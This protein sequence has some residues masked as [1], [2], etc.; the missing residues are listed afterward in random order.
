MKKKKK[1]IVEKN[2]SP[3]IAQVQF[4]K[5]TIDLQR[6]IL[7]RARLPGHSLT[8][9]P[10]HSIALQSFLNYST[11]PWKVCYQ[12]CSHRI[13]TDGKFSAWWINDKDE[14][15]ICHERWV[16]KKS[17][18]PTELELVT[19]QI[20]VP[21]RSWVQILSTTQILTLSHAGDIFVLFHF[22]L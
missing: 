17:E 12:I 1:K 4:Y 9:P 19:S 8:F 18:S 20:P 10:A 3:T 13:M 22:D 16:N 21:G 2:L 7:L 11:N 6:N 15:L 5:F 14:M